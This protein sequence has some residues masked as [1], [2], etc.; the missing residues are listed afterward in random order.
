MTKFCHSLR[1]ELFTTRR[2][3]GRA[4]MQL[5]RAG[6]LPN[7][8]LGPAQSTGLP[9]PGDLPG[10]SL[11]ASGTQALA[12]VQQYLQAGGIILEGVPAIP[13]P[14]GDGDVD[15]TLRLGH[16]PPTTRGRQAE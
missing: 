3:L 7:L 1:D 4:R 10:S 8:D 5:R 11:D 14:A 13:H 6:N 12:P 9:F 2:N 16:T 15:T